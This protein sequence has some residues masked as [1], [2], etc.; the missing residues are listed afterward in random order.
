MSGRGAPLSA[1]PEN[2]S[3]SPK[4]IETNWAITS[5]IVL[6]GSDLRHYIV[7]CDESIADH[8]EK[9]LSTYQ[10]KSTGSEDRILGTWDRPTAELIDM[11]DS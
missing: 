5:T 11:D 9:D 4:H 2:F 8:G 7:C 10:Q 1:W 6:R 3:V